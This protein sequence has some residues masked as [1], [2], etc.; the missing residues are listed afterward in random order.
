MFRSPSR[1]TLF[2]FAV[3]ASMAL[4]VISAGVA[5]ANV[6][7]LDFSSASSQYVTFGQAADMGQSTFTIELWFRRDGTGTTASSG[8]GGVTAVPLFCKGRGEAD[9]NNRDCNYFF[10]I[11]SADNVL[12]ADFEDM[13]SG[14]NHPV[15]GTTPI[16]TGIWY[17]AAATY[18]GTTWK[19]YLNGVL[20]GSAAAN[21]TPRFDS[22]QHASLATAMTSTG[23]PAGYFDGVIDEA[24]L[25]DFARDESEIQSTLYDEIMSGT[26]LV[27]RWGL[28]ENGGTLAGNSMSGGSDGTLVNGPTWVSGFPVADQPPLDP[29]GLTATA[30][31]PISV[32]LAWMDNSD[33]ESN[34]QVERSDAGSGGPFALVATVG[35][36][37]QAYTDNGLTADSE[38]CYRVRAT[39]AAGESGY[40]MVECATT[41]VDG[42]IALDFGGSADYVTFGPTSNLGL[43]EFT[44][45][46]WMRRDGTGST[47]STGSG[48]FNGVPLITKGRGESDGSNVDCN[49]FFG[50]A[51]NGAIAADFEDLASGL[52]HPV[53]GATP[54]AF[55][56]WHHV[57]VTYDGAE[58]ALYLDGNLDGAATA[59]ATPRFDSIQHAG[60]ATAMTSTGA[61]AG[62]F[63]GV[64][65]EV[66]I[67]DHARTVSEI[68]TAINT[69]IEGPATG[70][71][72]R[73][74][75]DEGMGSIVGSSAGTSIDGLIIGDD[76]VWTAG[77]PF[78]VMFDVPAAPTDLT[79][80]NGVAGRIVVSWSDNSDD[81]AEFQV[82]RS[83]DGPSGT[84]S[85]VATLGTNST[86]YADSDVENG[87]EYCYRVRAENLQGPSDYSNVDCAMPSPEGDYALD[88]GGSDTYVTFGA[89]PELG[90]AE[91][92]LEC[93]FK[94]EGAGVTAGTGSGGFSGIPLVTKG[95]GE[96]DGSNVD[97]N[98][99][100]GIRGSDNVLGADFEDFAT[101]L[102]HPVY[103]MTPVTSNEWHHAAATFDASGVWRL[104][105]DGSLEA[106]QPTS[107]VPRYDSIQHA[108]LGSALNSAGTHE[109]Y[110][111]GVI[112]EARVWN[113]ARSLEEIRASANQ[114][115]PG[116]MTGL[117]ARWG[118][119]AGSGSGVFDTAGNEIDGTILGAVY[120]WVTPGA[121]FDLEYNDAP[122]LP[123][124]VA[125]S[126]GATDV[127]I[128]A[129]LEVAVEDPDGDDVT[130][131]FYG[132]PKSTSA[133]ADFTLIA[134][135][136]TQFYSET[137]HDVFH[138]Q[139]QWVVDNWLTE[140]I[141]YVG[142][143]GDIVQNGDDAPAEWVVANEAMSRLETVPMPDGMPFGL[144]VGNHDQT[145]IYDPDGTT[146][147]YNFYFGV[148]RFLGRSYYG[149][150]YGDNNDNHYDLFSA[151][152]MDFIVIYFELDQTPDQPILDWAHDLLT[153]YSDRRAIVIT[154]W[155]MGIGNPGSFSDQG[156][157]IYN[158]LKDQPNLFLMLGGHIHGEGQRTDVFNGN[159]VHSVLADY[160]SLANGG[161]GYLRIMEFSPA[162][163]EIRVKT[164][165]PYLD[166]FFTDSDSEFTLDYDM[167]GN[168]WVELGSVSGV[169]SGG[170]ASF[171]WAGL[172]LDTEY[173]WYV[174]VEDARA[175]VISSTWSFRTTDGTSDVS[176]TEIPRETRLHAANPNPFG[177]RTTLQLDLAK[178]APV[179][180][181][182]FGVD[183]RLVRT[184][185]DTQ[186]DAGRHNLTWDGNDESGRKMSSG[187]YFARLATSGKTQSQQLVLT[188]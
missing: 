124:L 118:L 12:A 32:D 181:Q 127:T 36:D 186:L 153:T 187:V 3:P 93:W 13:A 147:Y 144:A 91:F 17:H 6:S 26:G 47:A 165:S 80:S 88:L 158:A 68:Q 92:T 9:G 131:T 60:L 63:A 117:V 151:S 31:S 176:L 50:I 30:T 167:S 41:P 38:Y 135:P 141:V 56:E 168:D 59:N 162:N 169:A 34:F 65:D 25:W 110:F 61:A 111:D 106:E 174:K 163:N 73:Y 44:L 74:G 78:D 64:L 67:W 16:Q 4:T 83:T 53:Y 35:A 86:F 57:A 52:N 155:L 99:F 66:R 40:T 149:G 172:D 126:N 166:A 157:A 105:L 164:Y 188:R 122:N 7:A 142:H 107:A 159:V 112:D 23:A 156:L 97:C 154:H 133:G 115:I 182:V 116:S 37:V 28:D 19:L 114:A 46:C 120:D 62:A 171:D 183:G 184:L 43:S 98:Y 39:N 139:T 102:N 5:A 72:A 79:A 14:L 85:L 145:P 1:R 129:H 55:G 89:A 27:G 90:L 70:L 8:S 69:E 45:E 143:E 58:W 170:T 94:R 24:R 179:E 177:P 173:E 42:N 138:S 84:F 15:A 71:V 128:P 137:Y 108:A 160:Q 18:D 11:R 77:A 150:H 33:D 130:V 140:N 20:D 48:G 10:G 121:P 113:Y 81:E 185:V 175:A 119:N 125:P 2:S 134:L 178:T 49:Y 87:T 95:R 29:S 96:T 148:D 100:F 22:I 76:V 51:S 75:L 123:M 101:G 104:Y 103:G 152:G 132:R 82:E 146:F 109:G 161:N 21:A 180:V 136:D 54:I